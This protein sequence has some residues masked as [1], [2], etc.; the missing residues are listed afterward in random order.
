MHASYPTLSTQ[1]RSQKVRSDFHY[2]G[3]QYQFRTATASKKSGAPKRSRKS[4]KTV[5]A[6]FWYLW[7]ARNVSISYTRYIEQRENQDQADGC[8][9]KGKRY[10]RDKQ[11]QAASNT[12]ERIRTKQE[13]RLKKSNASIVIN[14]TYSSVAHCHCQSHNPFFWV[15]RK[16]DHKKGMTRQRATCLQSTISRQG[17]DRDYS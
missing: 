15:P 9:R 16:G 11:G 6:L 7:K 1:Q 8:G 5:Q 2:T 14:R 10:V 13:A 17:P 3:S 4:H 12:H